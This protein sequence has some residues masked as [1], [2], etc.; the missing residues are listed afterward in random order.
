MSV[1]LGSRPWDISRNK[2]YYGWIVSSQNS[3]AEALPTPLPPVLQ[4]VTVFGDRAY[5]E[6]IKFKKA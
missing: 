4:N 6:V 1:W 3:Q 2:Y 5:K